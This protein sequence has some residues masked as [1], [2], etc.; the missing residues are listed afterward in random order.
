MPRQTLTELAEAHLAM[1][2][3]QGFAPQTVACERASVMKLCRWWDKQRRAPSGL[4]DQ[5][6]EDFLYGPGGLAEG[7]AESSFNTQLS[8]TKR[9]IHWLNRRDIVNANVL[10]VM[11]P[12]KFTR[13]E[14][15]RL[16]LP[17][18]VDMV[19]TTENPL[20]RFILAFAFQTL[21]REG[22]MLSRQWRH[23]DL[24]AG[25]V[26]WFRN[27]TSSTTNGRDV[28]PI[29]ADLDREVRRWVLVY[30]EMVGEPIQDDWYLIPRRIGNPVKG[31]QL[32]P[33]EHRANVGEIVQKHAQ[34]YAPG[35][36]LT[37]QG[38]HIM[39]RSSAR[40]LYEQLLA[41]GHPDP[42]RIV[43]A[44]LGHASV[45]TTELYLGIRKDREKRDDALKGKSLLSV[46]TDNVIQLKA[47]DSA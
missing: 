36:D 23:F 37:G 17:A 21:G 11:T 41:A 31:W 20:E 28:L 22:E 44:M 26:D 13:R 35:V 24:A 2:T 38:A 39:R 33:H 46:S 32:F 43:Q 4:D 14:Y 1:R 15:L 16:N 40:A 8:Q 30:Q 3:R 7:L 12:M 25:R 45:V 34:R 42:A 29:T 19:E 5:A 10:D 47:V 9:F 18:L 27:K 6:M